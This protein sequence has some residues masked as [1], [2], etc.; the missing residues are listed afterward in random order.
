[1]HKYNKITIDKQRER[2]GGK[3]GGERGGGERSERNGGGNR[4]ENG[5]EN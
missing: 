4:R 1:M 2:R 5:N 3:R